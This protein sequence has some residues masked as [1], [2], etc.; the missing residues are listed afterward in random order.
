MFLA[1]WSSM[2]KR[3][4]GPG[5]NTPSLQSVG[6][7][8]MG[9]AN[10]HQPGENGATRV[11]AQR[12]A[13]ELYV[14]QPQALRPVHA[15]TFAYVACHRDITASNVA[16]KATPRVAGTVW[17]QVYLKYCVNGSPLAYVLGGA[18]TKHRRT[19]HAVRPNFEHCNIIRPQQSLW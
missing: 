3:S 19:R 7:A 12:A 14:S 8:G 13:P 18:A 10:R 15:A 17:M 1:N 9:L 5:Q 6:A 16:C 2:F 4:T 11:L